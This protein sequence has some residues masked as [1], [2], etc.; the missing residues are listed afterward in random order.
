MLGK[1]IGPAHYAHI[2]NDQDVE[3]EFTAVY[4]D[5]ILIQMD[6]TRVSKGGRIGDLMKNLLTGET[7]RV[8]TMYSDP[9]YVESFLNMYAITNHVNQLV[10]AGEGA[11]RYFVMHSDTK[12]LL[13]TPLYKALYRGN[14]KSYFD[15][16]MHDMYSQDCLG[17]RTLANFLYH[18]PLGTFDHRVVPINKMLVQQKLQHISE[19]MSWWVDCLT[20]KFVNM[21]CK[22]GPTWTNAHKVD[23]VYR[24]FKAHM[25]ERQ[26]QKSK[27]DNTAIST[28]TEFWHEFAQLLPQT[29]QTDA[30]EPND[31]DPNHF[32]VTM[33]PIAVCREHIIRKMPGAEI[34]FGESDQGRTAPPL[35]QAKVD[36]LANLVKRLPKE[37]A[38]S[39]HKRF[40]DA[41]ALDY[42][43]DNFWGIN[44]REI[45]FNGELDKLID[46]EEGKLH[47]Y[48]AE[49]VKLAN[50]SA[51]TKAHGLWCELDNPDVRADRNSN[52][53][54]AWEVVGPVIVAKGKRKANPKPVDKE[55][56]VEVEED[57]IAC[58]KC[59]NLRGDY[60][61]YSC[62]LEPYPVI[63]A[64]DSSPT[65][66]RSVIGSRCTSCKEFFPPAG[67]HLHANQTV[68]VDE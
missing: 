40:V 24:W 5:K 12:A 18:V 47:D 50:Q 7:Q 36:R 60:A 65:G 26:G 19:I 63:I 46:A 21:Q 20:T 58:P 30:V 59:I 27:V 34:L 44:L 25:K 53:A 64:D 11:R 17:L 68:V 48:E 2:Q 29:V 54:R 6:E 67:L 23:E 1:I 32:Y 43:P 35:S 39:Y 62:M 45:A 15:S 37:P 41:L 22:D 9:K 61:A 33:P 10:P 49:G 13:D 56:E 42:L 31:P 14:E 55:P 51:V 66:R 3:G 57:R 52:K 38:D 4:Q 8:R 16:I 28:L